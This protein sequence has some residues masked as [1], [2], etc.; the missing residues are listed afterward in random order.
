M[1]DP[2]QTIEERWEKEFC[3]EPAPLSSGEDLTPKNP[4]HLLYRQE[5]DLTE[6][7][8][9]A[10]MC[11]EYHHEDCPIGKK[12]RDCWCTPRWLT[13]LLPR[14]TL[15]PCSN[16]FS[17]V[18]ALRLI[19]LEPVKTDGMNLSCTNR[20]QG[21]GL[22]VSWKNRSIFVNPPYSNIMPW[23][24]KAGEAKAFIFLVNNV[25]TTKWYRELLANG[26]SY[27][28]EFDKRLK[29]EPPPRIKPSSN[30]RDQVLICNREGYKMIGSALDGHGRWWVE[31]VGYVS[32]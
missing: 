1:S 14:V 9:C 3:S 5:G 13:D 4:P 32:E 15:D 12:L 27:K 20:E 21:D 10:V 7:Q 18:N 8:Q 2:K 29:F 6:Q 19:Q 11:G 24:R 28:F 25:T 17:T 31:H 26:G 30:S 22:A 16:P 23:A